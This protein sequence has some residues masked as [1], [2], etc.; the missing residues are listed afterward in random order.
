MDF[1][2]QQKYNLLTAMGYSG[3]SHAPE[4]DAF[5]QSNPRAAALM[6]KFNRVVQ[7]RTGM[8]EGGVV[9][10]S[11]PVKTPGTT[12]TEAVIQQP[13]ALTTKADVAKVAVTPETLIT[14]TAGQ[15][16]TPTAT[17][18]TTV[19]TVEK[20]VAPTIKPAETVTAT[21]AA[22]EVAK[23][24]EATTAATGE[25]KA[26]DLTTAAQ[27]TT[28]SLEGLQA[29]QGTGILMDNPVQREIQAGEIISGSA[30]DASKVTAL[31]ESIQAAEATPTKQATVQGQLEGLMQ[32]FEGGATPAWAAG[33]MRSAQA[34][35]VQRG[36]GASSVAGQAVIQAAMESALPIAQADATTRAQFE[37]QNLSNRQ[38]VAMFAAQQR[39]TFLGQEFDQNFQSRV[40]NAAKVSDIAN[41]NFTAEQTI[42]LENSRIANT[43]NL[44]NLD[45]R[46][47]MVMAQAAALSN[48]DITNLNNRQQAA[49]QNAQA[50]LQMDMANLDNEQQTG[51]FRAQANIN[52]LLTDS[53][54]QNAAKQFN[55]SSINQTNQFF[56]SLTANVSQ[57]NAAQKNAMDQ[58]NAGETNAVDKFNAQLE[59]QREQ[60]NANNGLVIAQANAVWRQN[61]TTLDTAAQNQAN[62]ASALNMNAM[63]AR[64]MDEVWQKERDRLAFAFTS[65]ESEKDRAAQLLLG[66]KQIEASNQQAADA[67]KGAMAA[68]VAKIIFGGW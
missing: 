60:F 68:V 64:G 33:A 29:A 24:A 10:N 25:V 37:S 17:T 2:P 53:A 30:V 21:T 41:M 1:S 50:F 57:F 16:T 49:V 62:A 13:E 23:V 34:M 39:A 8:V 14:P 47:G 5:V 51:L 6:G 48:L 19:D 35:L 20:A 26:Q 3:S 28:S 4:M 46:Q 31:T 22:P 61:A 59:A 36:L 43:V 55:A 38:Q 18:A 32:Q 52:A 56:D 9:T 40:L 45:N 67:E 63:T 15:V 44:A 11:S 54:A 7:K 58:Y 27:Q 65:V 42:A 12:L 66:N